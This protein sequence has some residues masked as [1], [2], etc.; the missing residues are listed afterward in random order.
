MHFIQKKNDS[1]IK[2]INTNGQ[3][4]HLLSID[5]KITNVNMSGNTGY[6]TATKGN[7]QK[8][9]M[10]DLKNGSLNKIIPV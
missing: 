6:V 7:N 9:Y 10:Y 1:A 8:V 3:C 2:F 4:N 5:G